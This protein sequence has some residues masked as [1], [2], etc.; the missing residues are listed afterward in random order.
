MKKCIYF[1]MAK[2][3]KNKKIIQRKKVWYDRLQIFL[4]CR[5]NENIVDIQIVPHLMKEST[6]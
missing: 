1:E 2:Q 6:L 5:K 3:Q 4:N